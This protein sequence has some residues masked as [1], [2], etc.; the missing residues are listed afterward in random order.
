MIYNVVRFNSSEFKSQKWKIGIYQVKVAIMIKNAPL[1]LN[2]EMQKI[3]LIIL[4]SSV[5]H[6]NRGILLL[7]QKLPLKA[8][9]V[10]SYSLN[11]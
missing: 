4:H 3:L 7:L 9:F 6:N 8:E 5:F 10:P 2:S 11:N 1:A